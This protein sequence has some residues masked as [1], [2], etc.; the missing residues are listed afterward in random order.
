M[1][2]IAKQHGLVSWRFATGVAHKACAA[3]RKDTK[4]NTHTNADPDHEHEHK[5]TDEV[6]LSKE[7]WKQSQDNLYLNK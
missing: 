7:R 6:D 3:K 1:L 4:D 5:P 2:R